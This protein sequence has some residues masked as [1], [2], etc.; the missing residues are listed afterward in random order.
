M[1]RRDILKGAVAGAAA[2]AIPS[3][4]LA[5]APTTQ[6]GG[7]TLG[8][9][10]RT[11]EVNGKSA[12]V[13]G[14]RGADDAPGLRLRA[15]EA[16][17]VLLRNE[18]AEPTIIHWH[19]LTPPWPSDGVADAPL[20]LIGAR[21]DR[22][23]DFPVGEP[24]TFWM[25][26]HTL[27]EQLLLAAPLIV[28]DPADDAKDEQ[29]IVILL[30]DF[31]FSSPE[32]LLAG[33]QSKNTGGSMDGM[34]MSGAQPAM[35]GMND[36]GMMTDINDIDYDAYLANDRP[37]DDPEI[38]PVERGGR[39]RMR[40]IN[41]ATATAFTVDFGELEGELI[42]VDGQP[43]E[44]VK[45]RRFPM[46]MGQRIDVRAQLPRDLS[47]SFPILALR[48]GSKERTGIVLRPAGATVAKLGTTADV[49][50]PIL[51]LTL[52]AQLRA[53]APLA[54]R[55]AN[56]TFEMALTGDMA[57]YRWG[58]E[59][60]APILVDKGDRVEVTL[61]NDTMMAH[62]MHLHGHHFQVVAIDGQRFQGAVRDTVLVP[63][64]RSITIAVDAVNP[65]KWAFHC[66]HLYHMA[67]GMMSTFAY[68]S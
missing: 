54:S 8:I 40:I 31:S 59:A 61:R 47:S 12:S 36:G 42:A 24:G 67:S 63:P 38:V 44:P 3:S 45:G 30:H 10:R 18:T 62:P 56:K 23:F 1:K 29:E 13:F 60:S 50:A 43:V 48:E 26:A 16:F 28:A 55:L 35:A 7:Q 6:S 58:L 51:D 11:I 64:M 19:G 34:D 32:E 4:L 39:V 20:P 17:N 53:I 14:L 22:S 52:E 49:D 9:S 21:A 33:L 15:G 5:V 2:F 66:H 46:T 27:Q 65:G 37:L 57:T 25:H 68:R 41:G